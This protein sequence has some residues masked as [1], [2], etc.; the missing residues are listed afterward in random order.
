MNPPCVLLDSRTATPLGLAFVCLNDARIAPV[1]MSWTTIAP[2]PAE[3]CCDDVEHRMTSCNGMVRV[4]TR[5]DTVDAQ[6]N[7]EKLEF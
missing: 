5:E 1:W 4:E 2:A 3:G 6:N 7:L